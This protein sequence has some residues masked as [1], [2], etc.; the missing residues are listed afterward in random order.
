MSSCTT[1]RTG[2]RPSSCTERRRRICRVRLVRSL[3]SC[4]TPSAFRPHCSHQ[5]TELIPSVVPRLTDTRT[6]GE[7]HH[8]QEGSHLAWHRVPDFLHRLQPD[9]GRTGLLV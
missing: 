6:G 4:S 3:L 2:C 8:G 1:C 5:A 7:G 9:V